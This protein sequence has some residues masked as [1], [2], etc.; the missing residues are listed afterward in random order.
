MTLEK[1]GAGIDF[2]QD[3]PPAA[4]DAVDGDTFLDTSA[5]PP[6]IKV[7]DAT[8]GSFVRPQVGIDWARKTPKIDEV[9]AGG[10]LSVSGAGYLI[11]IFP[12]DYQSGYDGRVDPLK[13]DGTDLLG[14]SR[15]LELGD[16]SAQG[17]SALN[18]FHRFDNSL[19]VTEDSTS[20][21]IQVSYVLD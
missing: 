3:T 13:L 2:V 4:S 6:Q 17:G 14:T 11:G 16:G 10:T 8:A 15:S 12:T 18:F 21:V 5:T 1:L 7:F 19:E 20:A 9:A